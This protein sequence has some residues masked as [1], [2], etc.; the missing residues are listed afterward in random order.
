MAT[1]GRTESVYHSLKT[2][3]KFDIPA[4]ELHKYFFKKRL[5]LS[6]I[7]GTDLLKMRVLSLSDGL[8]YYVDGVY[9]I[10]G[11]DNKISQV[12][13]TDFD[14]HSIAVI[15]IKK[16]GKYK[17]K[18]RKELGFYFVTLHDI[19]QNSEQFERVV[20]DVTTHSVADVREQIIIE[21]SGVNND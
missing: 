6:D 1:C 13:I 20:E 12:I 3:L 9:S 5:Q 19:L 4:K 2:L 21:N 10:A 16:V 11:Q 15:D 17:E 18:L 8:V 7:A 14:S